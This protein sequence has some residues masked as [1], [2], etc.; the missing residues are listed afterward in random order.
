MRTGIQAIVASCILFSMPALGANPFGS[1]T[2]PSSAPE[3]TVEPTREPDPEKPPLQRWPVET[4]ILMGLLTS[5]IKAQNQQIAILRT[6]APHSQTY[7]MRYG[8][9][10]GDR[11]GYVTAFDDSGITVV[12]RTENG[13]PEHV[14]IIV[15]NRGV[16]G[17]ND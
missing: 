11:D 5:D 13:S 12:Q 4:Y 8:D 17:V 1:L 7:L 14:R 10:L 9:L 3:P 15:R 16:R 6:P 2:P